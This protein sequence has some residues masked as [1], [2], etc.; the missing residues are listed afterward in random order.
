MGK[1]E[2]VQLI[3]LKEEKVNMFIQLNNSL[4]PKI[5]I[6]IIQHETLHNLKKII[7][8]KTKILPPRQV[9]YFEHEELLNDSDTIKEIGIIENS[10]LY[11]SD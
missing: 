11:L 5:P 3:I 7:A 6:S 8:D 1:H 10:I 4:Q 2:E 9:L